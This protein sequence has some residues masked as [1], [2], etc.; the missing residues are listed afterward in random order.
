VA[1][2]AFAFVRESFD[3]V[4][5]YTKSMCQESMQRP[6][7]RIWQEMNFFVETNIVRKRMS[8]LIRNST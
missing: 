2:L 6:K 5:L 3:P 1:R 4:H 8:V 7:R